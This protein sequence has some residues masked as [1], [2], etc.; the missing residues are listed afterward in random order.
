MDT[1]EEFLPRLTFKNSEP[2]WDIIDA[3]CLLWKKI[4]SNNGQCA[5]SLI[6]RYQQHGGEECVERKTQLSVIDQTCKTLFADFTAQEPHL[7]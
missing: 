2:F 3:G 4:K 6:D 5:Y 1:R 7:H